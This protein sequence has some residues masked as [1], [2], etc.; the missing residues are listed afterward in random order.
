MMWR[1]RLDNLVRDKAGGLWT[2]IGDTMVPIH[3]W[4]F[5]AVRKARWGWWIDRDC[6]FVTL[7]PNSF[8]VLKP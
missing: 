3:G 1:W 4:N 5:C 6:R 2:T 7:D 8:E